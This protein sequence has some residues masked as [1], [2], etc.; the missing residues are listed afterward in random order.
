MVESPW[1]KN[2]F[3]Y[4]FNTRADD[5]KSVFVEQTFAFRPRNVYNSETRYH[6]PIIV[7]DKKGK[8]LK[9]IVKACEVNA[10][11]LVIKITS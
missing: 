10:L 6:I 9:M 4:Y 3:I 11:V 5:L 8:Q 1:L 7:K 2:K